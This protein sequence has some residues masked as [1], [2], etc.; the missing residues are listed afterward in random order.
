MARFIDLLASNHPCIYAPETTSF[1]AG[2]PCSERLRGRTFY[3]H[4]AASTSANSGVGSFASFAVV[5]TT[6]R[7]GG[8]LRGSD[9][10]RRS[11]KKDPQLRLQVEYTEPSSEGLLGGSTRKVGGQKGRAGVVGLMRGA[12]IGLFQQIRVGRQHTHFL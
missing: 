5:G 2:H 8:I 1:T 7:G 10:R 12:A 4:A 11:A 3:T 6:K 9:L